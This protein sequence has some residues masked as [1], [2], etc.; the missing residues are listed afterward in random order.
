MIGLLTKPGANTRHTVSSRRPSVKKSVWLLMVWA[1]VAGLAAAQT[2]SL[3]DSLPDYQPRQQ[4]A[5]T[6]RIWGH[7]AWGKDFMESLVLRWEAGFKK[8]QPQVNFETDLLGTATAMGALYTG[9]GDIAILGREVRPSEIEAFRDVRGYPPLA[10]DV[11][12]GSYDVP[13]KDFALGIF[14]NQANPLKQLTM[15]QLVAV[16][17]CGGAGKPVARTWGDLGVKGAWA[18]QPI[19]AYGYQIRRGFGVYFDQVVLAGSGRW[20]CGYKEV[21]K[22]GDPDADG[23][24]IVDTVAGDPNAIAFAGMAYA[25]PE[26]R[27]LAIARAAAGPYVLP[28]QQSVFM[29]QYPLYRVLTSYVDRKPGQPMDAKMREFLSYILSRQGQQAIVDTGGYL[30]LNSEVVRHERAKL[31]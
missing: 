31:Q 23:Q 28:S 29:R 1:G 4:V 27:P 16:F 17:G 25:N 12:A 8:Y 3:V 5:G 6:I 18:K 15:A 2:A 10:I 19:H 24:L 9:T 13:N 7:G 26:V 11:I 20:N 21:F 14:V 30:P 22:Q